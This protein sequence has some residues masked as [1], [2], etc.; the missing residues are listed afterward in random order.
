[1]LSVHQP[2]RYLNVF[3]LLSNWEHKRTELTTFTELKDDAGAMRIVN[4]AQADREVGGKKLILQ[5]Y[6]YANSFIHLL[7]Y[8]VLGPGRGQALC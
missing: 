3:D 2:T 7:T 6:S 1:M 5:S 8:I 4:R